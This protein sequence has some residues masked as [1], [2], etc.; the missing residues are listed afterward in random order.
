[1]MA[2]QISVGGIYE[3]GGLGVAGF[4]DKP[5]FG[6][7]V[8]YCPDTCKILCEFLISTFMFVAMVAH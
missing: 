7:F 3:A 2:L 6:L 4:W 5:F 8:G 1:M